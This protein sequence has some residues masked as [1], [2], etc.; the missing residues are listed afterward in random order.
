MNLRLFSACENYIILG[1]YLVFQAYI[2]IFLPNNQWGA[3][4]LGP[5]PSPQSL[6]SSLCRCNKDFQVRV[7]QKWS[8]NIGR[9]NILW[10]FG[11]WNSLVNSIDEIA[12]Y[13]RCLLIDA[14]ND[15]LLSC[16]DDRIIHF[17]WHFTSWLNHIVTTLLWISE[18][19]LILTGP[20]FKSPC[21]R[22]SVLI[23]K[24]FGVF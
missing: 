24:I 12:P 5:P 23:C 14:D 19:V 18:F 20:D 10:P 11:K 15:A 4:A 13:T 1:N 21:R 22:F 17:D 6:L 7:F 2:S 8:C 16:S 9:C 3:V